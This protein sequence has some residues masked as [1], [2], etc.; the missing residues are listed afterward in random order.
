MPRKYRGLWLRAQAGPSTCHWRLPAGGGWGHDVS[1]N[2]DIC[3][4]MGEGG[5]IQAGFHPLDLLREGWVQILDLAA[6][7]PLLIT[8]A[9]PGVEATSTLAPWHGPSGRSQKPLDFR[10]Q[11]P[12]RRLCGRQREGPSSGGDVSPSRDHP[13]WHPCLVPFCGEK[14][15]PTVRS[16]PACRAPAQ[17]F[18]TSDGEGRVKRGGGTQSSWP[19]T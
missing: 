4:G 10:A 6:L 16:G 2:L 1:T 5:S 11:L 19:V 9:F 14:P 17:F 8:V 18:L 15:C 12:I 3:P 13:C 7:E